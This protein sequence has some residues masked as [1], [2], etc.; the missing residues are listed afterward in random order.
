MAAMGL[1]DSRRVGRRRVGASGVVMSN[2]PVSV[3]C[4]PMHIRVPD[5]LHAHLVRLAGASGTSPE[6]YAVE[7][8]DCWVVEHRAKGYVAREADNAWVPEE[9]CRV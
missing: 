1:V 2:K 3:L 6:Q 7:A 4:I 9:G 8:I 5:H